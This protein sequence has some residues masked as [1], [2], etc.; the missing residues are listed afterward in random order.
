VQAHEGQTSAPAIWF[1]SAHVVSIKR[2]V[3]VDGVLITLQDRRPM[4]VHPM[5]FG[6]KIA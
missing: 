5:V 3:A 4:N 6:L 2:S 1:K